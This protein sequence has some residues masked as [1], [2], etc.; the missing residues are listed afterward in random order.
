[1]IRWGK[2][3][4]SDGTWGVGRFDFGYKDFQG[5]SIYASP[6]LTYKSEEIAQA[7][8]DILNYIDGPKIR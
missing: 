2:A 8:V 3:K 4:T 6:D 5:G 7:V 1:M